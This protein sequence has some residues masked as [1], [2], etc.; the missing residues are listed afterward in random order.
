MESRVESQLRDSG[1]PNNNPHKNAAHQQSSMADIH[2]AFMQKT[3]PELHSAASMP[4][5]GS[6]DLNTPL[7]MD[8]LNDNFLNDPILQ[9]FDIQYEPQNFDPQSFDPQGFD[10]F[11][12]FD[13]NA[14]ELD[15]LSPT[16]YDMN[17]M[18]NMPELSNSVGSAG[19]PTRQ[20]HSS[21]P[22]ATVEGL[23]I[24]DSVPKWHVPSPERK[25]KVTNRGI[26]KKPSKTSL[27][28][29][30]SRVNL[31]EEAGASIKQSTQEQPPQ[32]QFE[33]KPHIAP[34]QPQQQASLPP[35]PE[36]K[37][38][39]PPQVQVHK[40]PQHVQPQHV[41]TQ[42]PRAPSPSR[43]Q[44]SLQPTTPALKQKGRLVSPAMRSPMRPGMRSRL[45]AAA[46]ATALYGN[47]GQQQQA[48][49]QRGM[50]AAAAAAASAAS[51]TPSLGPPVT[52]MS[53]KL[54]ANPSPSTLVMSTKGQGA[55][56]HHNNNNNQGS[57][58]SPTPAARMHSSSKLVSQASDSS[59][60]KGM[61]QQQPRAPLSLSELPPPVASPKK[62]QSGSKQSADTKRKSLKIIPEMSSSLNQFQVELRPRKSA[63]NLKTAA[64]AARS[65]TKAAKPGKLQANSSSN[66][67]FGVPAGPASSGSSSLSSVKSTSTSTPVASHANLNFA[68][69]LSHR[70]SMPTMSQN[71]NGFENMD[72]DEGLDSTYGMLMYDA[73]QSFNEPERTSSAIPPVP[74][75]LLY[76]MNSPVGRTSTA[77]PNLGNITTPDTSL[78]DIEQ[79]HPHGEPPQHVWASKPQPPK[80]RQSVNRK[81]ADASQVKS[82]KTPS[83]P[84]QMQQQLQ[85]QQ[86]LRQQ[87]LLQEQQLQQQHLQMAQ[88]HQTHQLQQAQQDARQA[89]Q[90]RQEA[91]Q[92]QQMQKAQQAQMQ[93][94]QAQA[95]AQQSLQHQ[96]GLRLRQ[97]QVQSQQH[98]QQQQQQQYIQQQQLKQH[99]QQQQQQQHQHQV[100]PSR[101][102]PIKA[103][104]SMPLMHQESFSQPALNSAGN[105]GLSSQAAAPGF[106]SQA[107]QPQ[108]GFDSTI[109]ADQSEDFMSEFLQ[110]FDFDFMES[111]ETI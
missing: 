39:P 109:L 73:Q 97:Q 93:L 59:P 19:S 24:A 110:D 7:D 111:L 79:V 8:L 5:F 49:R 63:Q 104:Q 108:H 60:A 41:Q 50:A 94:Q 13:L 84:E 28:Q 99:Q 54:N 35:K 87:Q 32:L 1:D 31:N 11:Q 95:Q 107:L 80:R 88:A 85:Q 103:R 47:S 71:Y 98:Q 68:T 46:A 44:V 81:R 91:L 48:P 89:Q 96:Q 29:R 27:K 15:P 66:A 64:P 17:V 100:Q 9:N 52:P 36:V 4:N 76:G 25:T 10:Q 61:W 30:R 74:S 23:G 102:E 22:Y 12:H 40:Q 51:N 18:Q 62:L 16:F 72:M 86:Q 20:S 3:Y 14:P 101:A 58:S 21:Q 105:M 92:A 38:H 65:A 6:Y 56:S 78:N 33:P 83:I 37:S 57:A 70:Q 53:D 106:P 75:N 69:P 42:I 77:T 34:K 82:P 26:T 2:A 55:T 45:P 67:L 43:S 90:A